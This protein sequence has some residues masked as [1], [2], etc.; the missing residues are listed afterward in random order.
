DVTG[1]AS[2]GDGSILSLTDL[3]GLDPTVGAE[4]TIL[5]SAG[6]TGEFATV[7][8]TL[9]DGDTETWDV[10][11]SPG[12]YSNDVVLE[13]V[14]CTGDAGCSTGSGPTATP[15]PSSLLMLGAG[16]LML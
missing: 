8:N 2:L 9:F 1:T 4:Y 12:G 15:E 14:A 10:L 7:D 11:Y 3:D 13:A 6:L 16:L 5:E